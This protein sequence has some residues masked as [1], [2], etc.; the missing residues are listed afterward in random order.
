MSRPQFKP[1]VGTSDSDYLLCGVFDLGDRIKSGGHV[2]INLAEPS[3][4]QPHQRSAGCR[5]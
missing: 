3:S 2:P 4:S 5:R 1:G